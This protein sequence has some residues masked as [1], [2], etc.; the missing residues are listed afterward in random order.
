MNREIQQSQSNGISGAWVIALI[1]ICVAGRAM[2][3]A[4]PVNSDTAM[5]VYAGKLVAEGGRPGVDLLDNKLPS[6]GLLMS[7]PWRVFG[8]HWIGYAALGFAMSLLATLFL[9]RVARDLWDLETAKVVA[10]A[11]ALW[12]NFP[13]AV[14]GQLQLETIQ[15]T[16]ASIAGACVLRALRNDDARD[17]FTAGLAASLATW[18]KPTGGAVLAAAMIAM[19]FSKC[20]I[21]RKGRTLAA[22]AAG[23][24]IPLMACVFAVF[25]A[26]YAEAL[27]ATL[28]Q[29]RD[30]SA[31]STIAPMDAAKPAMVL[32]LLG[33]PV[34]VLAWLFRR[35]GRRV[36]SGGGEL[37]FVLLWL[38]A[39]L[40]GVIS[41]RRMYAYHF[42]VLGPPA[43]LLTGMLARRVSTKAL[44]MAFGPAVAL[45]AWWTVSTMTSLPGESRDDRIIAYVRQQTPPGEAVWMDDYPRLLVETG[46]PAGSTV[47]LIFLMANGDS[48]PDFFG[49]Q[50]LADFETKRPA[51]IAFFADPEKLADLYRYHMA[52]V[53]S[54]PT[55]AV[56]MKQQLLALQDYLRSHYRAETDIGDVRIWRR[57]EASPAVSV[58]A[59]E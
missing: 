19:L 9:Y 29:L 21:K 22:M 45:S 23:G 53:S 55:R 40:A 47:P 58:A 20:G 14:Y 24:A 56:A 49:R 6:V 10:V 16:L 41:Q 15:I 32:G 50:L 28:K 1:L 57:N 18:A 12:L 8:A 13:P 27:P 42:L 48:A 33:F 43:A 38:G 26:G 17:A 44:M 36:N 5:F 11:S 59:G 4:L 7:V 54:S 2:F 30:Y 52:E 51:L 46:R 3:L 34:L 39:E 31:Q 25:T 37:L 35:G